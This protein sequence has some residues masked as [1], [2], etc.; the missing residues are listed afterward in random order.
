MLAVNEGSIHQRAAEVHIS[1]S[2]STTS[3]RQIGPEMED[4]FEKT[5]GNVSYLPLKL[6]VL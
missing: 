2:S 3:W 6:W 5:I 4:V 1:G